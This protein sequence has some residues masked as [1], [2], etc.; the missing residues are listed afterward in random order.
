MVVF[1]LQNWSTFRG[2][3]ITKSAKTKKTK[4]RKNWKIDY[5]FVS[6]HCAP[7]VYI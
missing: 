5:S 3:L 7:F 1:V 6:A 4:Y 2:F